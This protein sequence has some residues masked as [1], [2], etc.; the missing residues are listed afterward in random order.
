MALVY[1]V[2]KT[3]FLGRI[4]WWLILFTE[5]DFKVIHKLG[6][7]H[8]LANAWSK[9]PYTKELKGVLNEIMNVLFSN[10][11]GYKMYFSIYK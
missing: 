8:F 6:Q 7:S 9:L 5:Y 1:L 4:V 11:N 2:K 3:Q 10:H